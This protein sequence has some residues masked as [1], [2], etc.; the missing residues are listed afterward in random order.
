MPAVSQKQRAYLNVHFGHAWVK[1]H[2]FDNKGKLPRYV[3]KKPKK[4][5]HKGTKRRSRK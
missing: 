5:K 3:G 4:K 1:E 2:G